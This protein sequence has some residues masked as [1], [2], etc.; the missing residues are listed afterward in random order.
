VIV[1]ESSMLDLPLATALFRATDAPLILVG[2]ADQLPSVGP[3]Q[4]LR[5]IIDSGVCPV[6]RLE[7][8]FRQAEGSGILDAAYKVLHGQTLRSD[9]GFTDFYILPRD[10]AE[11]GRDTVVEV[12]AQRL[13]A[14]GFADAQ[15]LAPTRKGILGTEGLNLALQGRLN[16][17]GEVV[18]R[19]DREFRHGDRVIC[20]R[21]RYDVEVFNGD[22]GVVDSH[23]GAGLLVRFDGRI[24]PW[25]WDEWPSLELAYAITVHKSQGSE[26]AA[27]VLV[28]HPSHSVMLQRN[29]LYTAMTRAKRFLCIIGSLRAIDRA[30]HS[31]TIPRYTRLADRIRGTV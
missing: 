4:I 10:D 13:P 28:I 29:L 21:N 30:T 31:P 20:T 1:D 27:V 23:D 22:V 19:G 26:Y 8:T 16:P 17:S 24:V 12:A 7:R 2:D 15:V 14:R 6:I 5:D 18:K 25:V 3:G 9:L 11:R